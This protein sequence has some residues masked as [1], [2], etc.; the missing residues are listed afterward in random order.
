MTIQLSFLFGFNP[1]NRKSDIFDHSTLKT[2][3]IWPS[4]VLLGDFG[5]VDTT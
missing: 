2:V 3:H 5:D 4:V 1:S